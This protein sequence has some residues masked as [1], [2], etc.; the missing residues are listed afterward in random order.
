MISLGLLCLSL[1]S[2][3]YLSKL[4]IILVKLGSAIGINKLPH[5]RGFI[6][7][8][9]LVTPHDF[10]MEGSASHGHLETPADEDATIL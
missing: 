9:F 6:Q 1:I 5:L 4:R 2:K 8:L 7:S 10:H 3:K